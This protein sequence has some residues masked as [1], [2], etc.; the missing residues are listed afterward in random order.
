MRRVAV[1]HPMAAPLFRRHV[2]VDYSG[3]GTD[4]SLQRGLA[5]AVADCGRAQVVPERW[6]R[7][8]LTDWLT[9]LLEEG[10]P[11]LVALDHAFSYDA[12]TLRELRVRRWDDL[13]RR[14]EGLAPAELEARLGEEARLRRRLTDLWARGSKGPLDFR[15]PHGVA[16]SS[17]AGIRQLAT[18]R[19]RVD[20]HLW[21]FD[22]WEV[23]KGMSVVA[24]GYPSWIRQRVGPTP[25]SDE[26][27]RDAWSLAEWLRR[28][29]EEGLL[30]R[31]L[32]PP[33][34]FAERSQAAKE[35]WILGVA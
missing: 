12:L 10:V 23:P 31:Y 22:G 25:E 17:L 32:G 4:A 8:S 35:G 3:A 7:A 29:D 34:S 20:M 16:R 33:L 21:P 9:G 19:K 5:V 28:R 11:T 26:H 6:S 15:T 24:E 13:P 27:A 30:P 14:L 2:G 18:L 1:R